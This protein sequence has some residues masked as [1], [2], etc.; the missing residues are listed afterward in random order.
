[1]DN[2]EEV[3]LEKVPNATDNGRYGAT[4]TELLIS[5]EDQGDPAF[6]EKASLINGIS[7]QVV[8]MFVD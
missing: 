8:I 5:E 3:R 7:V 4:K 6:V 1:M 2:T